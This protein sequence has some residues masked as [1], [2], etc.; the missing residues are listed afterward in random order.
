MKEI[1]DNKTFWKTAQPY[2]SAKDNKSSKIILAENNIV[3]A[4]E[5]RVTE[6]MNKYFINITKNLNLKAPKL[7]QVTIFSV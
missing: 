6:L 2:F 3:I 7:T 5:K 4:D 1:G